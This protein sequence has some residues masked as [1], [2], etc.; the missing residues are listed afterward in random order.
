MLFPC[1][2]HKAPHTLFSKGLLD[3]LILRFIYIR[4]HTADVQ[5]CPPALWLLHSVVSLFTD[6]ADLC[7][8]GVYGVYG[9][10]LFV[11]LLKM[12]SGRSRGPKRF[13]REPPAG[14]QEAVGRQPSSYPWKP[15]TRS[16][17][18]SHSCTAPSATQTGSP[19][20]APKWA[21][22]TSVE[23]SQGPETTQLLSVDPLEA[24]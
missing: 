14:W 10:L 3:K 5:V 17:S 21:R 13:L 6:C 1:R 19:T 12:T 2:S 22:P 7:C 24:S 18:A 4:I 20:P 23:T 9:C 15:E 8:T 11:G 16:C